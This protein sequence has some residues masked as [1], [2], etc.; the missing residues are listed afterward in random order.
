[1]AHFERMRQ[2][3]VVRVGCLCRLYRYFMAHRHVLQHSRIQCVLL[4]SKGSHVIYDCQCR[5]R[6]TG[7][8]PALPEMVQPAEKQALAYR[9]L[10]SPQRGNGRPNRP[11]VPRTR[12]Y[13]G[14]GLCRAIRTVRSDICRRSALLRLPFPRVLRAR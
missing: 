12:V 11:P 1:M 8:H 4:P 3:A 14:T 6:R 9:L 10:P 13:Q 7:I 2:Q 5:I